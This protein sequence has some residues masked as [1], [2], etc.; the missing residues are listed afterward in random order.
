MKSN[1]FGFALSKGSHWTEPINNFLRK[2]D[3]NGKLA[4]IK[5]KYFASQCKEKPAARPEQFD[6]LY[7]S[8]ACALLAVGLIA[9][10]VVILVEHIIS[11][12]CQVHSRERKSSYNVR[13]IEV[14]F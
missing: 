14:S 1:F 11:K 8:G 10:L 12:F 7:L 4:D 13:K 2:Y 6:L 3:E 9:S 5:R